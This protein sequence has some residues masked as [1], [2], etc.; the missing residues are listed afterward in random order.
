MILTTK[1]RA[2]K[3]G[4]I[5]F[6]FIFLGT[7]SAQTGT[8]DAFLKGQMK[9]LRIPGMQVT[10]V[11]HGKIALNKSYGMANVQDLVPVNNKSIFAINSCTKV[12]TG[13]AIMQLVEE[14]KIELSAPVSRYLDGLPSD[15][16]PVTIKQLLTHISGLPDILR[17]FNPTTHGIG[18]FGNEAAV[19]EKVKAMPMEFPT[20]EQ[21]R[22]NQTNYVLLG[23]IIDK[24]SGKPFARVFKERQFDIAGMSGTVFGDS[25]DVIPHFAP[26]YFYKTSI[27][28]QKLNEEKLTNNYSEFPAFQRT[29]SG[30]NSTGEDMAKWIIALQQGKLLQTK[31][32]LDTLWTAGKYNNGSPTQWAL[33]WGLTKFRSKHKAVGMS[34]GGR[35]AFLVYPDDDL[36]VIV[37]TNLGG[38]SPENF[39]EEIAG[40]YNPDIAATDPITVLRIQLK[41]RGFDKAMEVVTEEKKKDIT[42]QPAEND[43]N[44]WGYRMMRSEQNKEALEIFKLNVL[45][46]PESWNVY[47][48]YGEALLK[49]GQTE[50]A[51]KMYKRS[52]ELNPKNEGGKKV[53]EKMVK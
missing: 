45:L 28:G 30:L 53:L 36:A 29:G 4:L 20:G 31:A 24:L 3:A 23:K 2:L 25:R 9:E 27:D 49:V 47:D 43:L 48:S 14:G 33:G 37:L 26:T 34:G 7:V 22:Y 35:S 1:G 38:S 10:V 19:W 21:F 11:Q 50:E 15:W 12:F 32:A 18:E 51:I 16:Q 39:I 5:F 17:L 44:D 8:V 46:Y 40:Y 41:K 42:F 52:I 13:V 6:S